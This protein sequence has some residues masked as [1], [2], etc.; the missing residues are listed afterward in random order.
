MRES[1]EK[2]PPNNVTDLT[3]QQKDILVQFYEVTNGDHWFNN[4]GWLSEVNHCSWKGV[5]CNDEELVT[6]IDLAE[7]NLTGHMEP[8][9]SELIFPTTVKYVNI[10]G[11][12]ISGTFGGVHFF[13]YQHLEH[14]DIS[15]NNFGGTSE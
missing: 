1:C 3:L 10:S 4:S 13:D 2:D 9:Y 14:V 5:T 11:N 8:T 12:S 6:E 7:N 15:G